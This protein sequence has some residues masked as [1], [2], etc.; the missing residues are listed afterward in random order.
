MRRVDKTKYPLKGWVK[1]Q[2][3]W[4]S[5]QCSM[6]KQKMI[7]TDLGQHTAAEGYTLKT[8]SKIDFS[9][10][11][12]VYVAGNTYT[13]DSADSEIDETHGGRFRGKPRWIARLEVS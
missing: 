5:F 2:G 7:T 13:V 11:H 10:T 6:R 9:A 8:P 4:H 1:I 3:E 12:Q